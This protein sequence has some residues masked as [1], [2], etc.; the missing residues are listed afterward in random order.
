[1]KR[2]DFKKISVKLDIVLKLRRVVKSLLR[3]EVL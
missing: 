1:M 2:A 3:V